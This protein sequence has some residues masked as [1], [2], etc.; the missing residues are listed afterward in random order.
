MALIYIYD[1][2]LINKITEHGK[3]LLNI[4]VDY[5]EKG[6]SFEVLYVLL[7]NIKELIPFDDFLPTTNNFN[8]LKEK[9]SAKIDKLESSITSSA[10]IA[11]LE[12]NYSKFTE[13]V[14]NAKKEPRILDDI[15]NIM[16]D[17]IVEKVSLI[18]KDTKSMSCDLDNNNKPILQ[19]LSSLFAIRSAE[20]ILI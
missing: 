15:I 4:F 2:E 13:L 7:G 6:E 16:R 20:G 19:L 8:I 1:L 10:K 12:G 17:N 3:T 11:V 5:F 18:N 9:I 14:K